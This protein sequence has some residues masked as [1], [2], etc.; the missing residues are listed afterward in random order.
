[1]TRLSEYYSGAFHK[2]FCLAA[3]ETGKLLT[4]F[5]KSENEA[6]FI[7]AKNFPQVSFEIISLKQVVERISEKDFQV[8]LESQNDKKD[9][10]IIYYLYEEG[11][12]FR[13]INSS[14]FEEY[15]FD[16]DESP[17]TLTNFVLAYKGG[18]VREIYSH[19][20]SS[21]D[22][23]VFAVIDNEVKIFK[24]EE[25]FNFFET[26]G[27]GFI[28]FEHWSSI[29]IENTDSLVSYLFI[30]TTNRK[31]WYGTLD[32]DFESRLRESMNN[33]PDN[34]SPGLKASLEDEDE[35]G[36]G[37]TVPK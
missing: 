10:K 23:G 35:D 31:L 12:F 30:D 33:T 6:V 22:L 4:N 7:D 8:F 25:I 20:D 11:L 36:A 5:S 37:N 29:C 24:G 21:G 28:D 15:D 34:N 17:R 27:E 14:Y 26:D 3:F 2:E 1:M 19:T 18:L 9:Q 32:E 13:Y 16:G